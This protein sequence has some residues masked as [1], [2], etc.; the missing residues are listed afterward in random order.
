MSYF[1]EQLC[2]LQKISKHKGFLTKV[3]RMNCKMKLSKIRCM[4]KGR[5]L[6]INCLHNYLSCIWLQAPFKIRQI[7][8]LNYSRNQCFKTRT[9]PTVNSDLDLDLAMTQTKL[10]LMTWFA[11]TIHKIFKF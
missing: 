7:K 3:C 8:D 5:G 9:Q 6:V 2:T 4:A 1:Y 11:K 10:N